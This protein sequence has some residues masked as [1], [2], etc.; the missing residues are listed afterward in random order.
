MLIGA[1]RAG[2][3]TVPVNT[4]LSAA[5]CAAVPGTRAAVV[6]TRSSAPPV[7]GRAAR[8]HAGP[9][10]HRLATGTYETWLAAPEPVDGRPADAGRRRAADLHVRDERA[11]EGRAAHRPQPRRQGATGVVDRVGP[12]R[13]RAPA[14]WPPRCSTSARS[15]WGLA[16]LDAGATTILAGRRPSGHDRSPPHGRPGDARLPGAVDAGGSARRSAEDAR[17]PALRT[18]RLRGVADQ[19]WR[20][21]SGDNGSRAGPAPG[22]RDDRDHRRVHRAGARPVPTGRRPSERVGRPRIPLGRRRDPRPGHPRPGADRRGRRG[23]DPFGAELRGLPR[24]PRPRP[25][26]L[27][28]TAGCG[29]A[30]RA[31]STGTATSSSPAG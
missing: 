22:L 26:L 5:S 27:T 25:E 31:A 15:S 23:V 19:R 2:A 14:C 8:R 12:R 4:R 16:G 6:A 7:C 24:P 10:R 29:P 11:A 3:V 18:R 20:T 9:R 21:S 13:G 30:T 28:P 17:F 1:A